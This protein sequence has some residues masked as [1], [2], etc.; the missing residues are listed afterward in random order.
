[1]QDYKVGH[2]QVA[3]LT[4]SK[5]P[6]ENVLCWLPSPRMRVQFYEVARTEIAALILSDDHPN[7]L[8][9]FALEED[10]TFC[11]LGLEL[12]SR[13][14]ADLMRDQRSLVFDDGPTEFATEVRS[15]C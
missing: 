6:P 4:L 14:L 10:D 13:S 7:V 5:S 15:E 9:C 3:A 1:M 2:T 12:C 11:Y 8:R